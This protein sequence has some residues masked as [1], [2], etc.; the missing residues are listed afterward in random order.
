[1]DLA[2][3]AHLREIKIDHDHIGCFVCYVTT[4]QDHI[5]A[6]EANQGE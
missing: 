2:D 5:V 1:M 6:H 4:R 3:G